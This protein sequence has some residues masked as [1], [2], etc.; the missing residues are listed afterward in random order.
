[1]I[2][3]YII[4]LEE[5]IGRGYNI[6]AK[7]IKKSLVKKKQ[8]GFVFRF[9]PRIN[10]KIENIEVV[11]IENFNEESMSRYGTN[12]LSYRMLPDLRDGIKPIN[13][14]LLYTSYFVAYNRRVKSNAVIGEL[15]AKWHP[16]GDQAAYSSMVNM[17]QEWRGMPL[18]YGK[19]NFGSIKNPKS[20]AA[21]RYTEVLLSD[22]S[23]DCFFGD[24]LEKNDT[25]IVDFIPNFD[26]NALE[27]FY[28][29][30][31]YPNFLTNWNT[32]IAIGF[33]H[34]SAGFT[35]KDALETTIKLIKEG[36]NAEVNINISDPQGCDILAERGMKNKFFDAPNYSVRVRALYK[37]KEVGNGKHSLVITALPYETSSK[38][39]DDQIGKLIDNKL[40]NYVDDS[41]AIIKNFK[42]LE[43][44]IYLN[45]GYDPHTCMEDLYKRTNLEKTFSSKLLYINSDLN[46][47]DLRNYVTHRNALNAWIDYRREQVQRR[48]K[49]KRAKLSKEIH[50]REGLLKI[51]NMNKVEEF[52]KIV[53]TNK[54]KESQLKL[55]KKFKLSDLQAEYLV[56]IRIG[57]LSIDH[58]DKYIKEIKEMQ[59]EIKIL[60]DIIHSSKKIDKIII[61]ELEYGIKKYAKDEKISKIHML[62]GAI[63]KT[64]STSVEFTRNHMLKYLPD[65]NIKTLNDDHPFFK[66]IVPNTFILVY[67]RNGKFIN[68]DLTKLKISKNNSVGYEISSLG[69][70]SEAIG[71]VPDNSN[72]SIIM[73][74]RNGI[75]QRS[76]I[77]SYKSS[78]T[79]SAIKLNDDDELVGA[80]FVSKKDAVIIYT[81][82]GNALMLKTKDITKTNRNTKGVS[83]IKLKKDEYCV[84]ISSILYGDSQIVTIT[85]RGY[86]KRFDII[87]L[88]KSIRGKKGFGIM[89][90]DEVGNLVS[91]IS[92]NKDDKLKLYTSF[93]NEDIEIRTSEIPKKTRISKGKK[94]VK[95]PKHIK[96]IDAEVF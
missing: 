90:P 60:I 36:P 61:S 58:R 54:N 40:I 83:G 5:Y 82:L 48:T 44:S 13:R 89:S 69:L 64:S 67:G 78:K 11:S 14:R 66:S 57:L 26:D 63:E 15:L 9:K 29:P 17:S 53:K 24:F 72:G 21:M 74:T 85:D 73:I 18:I 37:V 49:L 31:R 41:Q 80:T 30:A 88:P 39:V 10:G 46:S 68:I 35:F 16:H 86:A 95:M 23:K 93:N 4:K 22:F 70:N 20:H 51:I 7:K 28:L 91:V 79:G 38:A 56:N 71:I 6:L 92:V 32:G 2:E 94:I 76:D 47:L 43:Y 96:I 45:K 84:G 3:V 62:G 12:V 50:I 33:S 25:T 52:I 1:M 77:D 19:G 87:T 27:P 42:D 8:E 59:A 75:I 55:I 34:T 81:N 65:D